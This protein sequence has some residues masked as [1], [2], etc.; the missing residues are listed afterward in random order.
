MA[1]VFGAALIV[2]VR[3]DS[4]P[5]GTGGFSS[6][7]LGNSSFCDFT[8]GRGALFRLLFGNI[9]LFM[10]RGGE[11]TIGAIL[12]G[13]MFVGAMFVGESHLVRHRA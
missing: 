2:G 9:S 10:L 3:V 5:V 13:A 11:S 7:V 6:P 1:P 8:S 12:L 4:A